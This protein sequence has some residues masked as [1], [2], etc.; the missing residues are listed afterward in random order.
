MSGN[1]SS[2]GI[3]ETFPPRY[4]LI[5]VTTVE[6]DIGNQPSASL[7]SMQMSINEK[8]SSSSMDGL[9]KLVIA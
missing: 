7:S 2:N 8:H 5:E 3:G 6:N 1:N 9:P 4:Y